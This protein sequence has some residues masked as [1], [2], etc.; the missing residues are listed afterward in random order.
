M[1]LATDDHLQRDLVR[2]KGVPTMSSRVLLAEVQRAEGERSGEIRRRVEGLATGD[3]LESRLDPEVR[4]Q[5][6]AIR[7]G[8][9]DSAVGEGEG[10]APP[11]PG[12]PPP[13][14][15]EPPGAPPARPKMRWRRLR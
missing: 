11:V 9:P 4:R 3:R 7:R 5:L 13:P 2:A 8:E 1:V 6:E 15:S 12:A 14:V 10:P